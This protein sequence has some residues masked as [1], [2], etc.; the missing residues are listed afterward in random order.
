M[1]EPMTLKR[2]DGIRI[3][4]TDGEIPF[5]VDGDWQDFATE[6]L[7]ELDRKRGL[8]ARLARIVMHPLVTEA[9]A[10]HE[11]AEGR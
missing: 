9:L 3:A 4:I 2:E 6:L 8:L 10:P 7:A 1:P 11:I 5:D